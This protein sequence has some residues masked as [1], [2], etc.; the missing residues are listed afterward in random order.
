MAI[1]ALGRSREQNRETRRRDGVG[2]KIISRRGEGG[3][4]K[5]KERLEN[6]D[7]FIYFLF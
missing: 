6:T 1:H 5:S 3:H 2:E 7:N 4:N